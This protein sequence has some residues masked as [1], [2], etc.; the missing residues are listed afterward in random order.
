[1][2]VRIMSAVWELDVSSTD[3]LVMLALADWSNDDG[4]CWPSMKQLADKSGLTDRAIRQCVGRMCSAGH[5]TRDE[6]PGKGVCYKVHPGTT[7]RPEQNSPRN[8]IP[9]TPE[10]RSANTS[11]HI[12][13]SEDKS[14]S[15]K[16]ARV[17]PDEFPCPVDVDPMDWDGLKANRK[18]KRAALSPGAH[19]QITNKLDMWARAGW[20][21]GPI[22]AHAVERGWTTVF[23]TDE[24]RASGNEHRNG[25]KPSTGKVDGFTAVL[26]EVARREH[27]PPSAHNG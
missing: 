17:K 3:K 16:R 14:S 23:E 5:L 12:I 25:S 6:K 10:R 19:R 9:K 21:P 24:M 27:E 20:P 15:G 11:E 26:R 13:P 22:V 4:V 1:M 8:D 2:S 18:A 7:F